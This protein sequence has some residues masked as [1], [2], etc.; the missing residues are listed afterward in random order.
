M[1]RTLS[2]VQIL[3]IVL[4]IGGLLGL[5]YGGFTY[6]K[7]THG[8][9]VGSLEVAVKDKERI[10][11]PLWASVGAVVGGAALLAMRGRRTA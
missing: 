6:T 2:S 7:E 10:N 5:A 11:V 8:F 4:I 9:K 3:A 1:S